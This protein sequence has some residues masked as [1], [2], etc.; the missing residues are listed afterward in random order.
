[1]F[2]AIARRFRRGLMVSCLS[3]TALVSPS[4]RA[5][6]LDGDVSLTRELT[7]GGLCTVSFSLSGSLGNAYVFFDNEFTL[8]GGAYFSELATVPAAAV[9]TLGLADC[10]ITDVTDFVQI[11]AGTDFASQAYMGFTFSGREGGVLY[12][13]EYALVGATNTQIVSTRTVPPNDPPTVAE[14]AD[15]IVASG[16]EYVM[17]V[18]ATDDDELGYGWQQVDTGGLAPEQVPGFSSP[19]MN[20]RAPVLAGGSENRRLVFEVRVEDG[21]NP[22]V[23]RDVAVTVNAPPVITDSSDVSPVA[24]AETFSVTVTDSSDALTYSWTQIDSSGLV[25]TDAIGETTS[26]FRV[27]PPVLPEGS[28]PTTLTYRVSVSDGV[29]TAI[30]Q[31]F[32]FTVTPPVNTPPTVDAGPDRTVGSGLTIGLEGSASDPDADA[33]VS[34]LWSAP[35]GGGTFS[36][37]ADAGSFYTA[38]KVAAGSPA[39]EITLTLEAADGLDTATSTMIV[40]VTPNAAPVVSAGADQTVVSGGQVS[41]NASATDADEADVAAMQYT[42]EAPEGLSFSFGSQSP[43]FTAPTLAVNAP[44]AVFDL[45]VTGTDGTDSDSDAMRLTVTSRKNVAPVAAAQS[46]GTVAAGQTITLSAAGTTDADEGDLDTLQ[47]E[48]TQTSGPATVLQGSLTSTATFA[49][50]TPVPTS[51]NG[52]YGFRVTVTDDDGATSTADVE[53]ELLS[54]LTPLEVTAMASQA[55]A[56]TGDFVQLSANVLGTNPAGQV[57]YNWTTDADIVIINDETQ[58]TTGFVAPVVTAPVEATFV[59]TVTET[60]PLRA[61]RMVSATVRVTLS[62]NSAPQVLVTG[63]ATATEGDSVTLDASGSSDAETSRLAIFWTQT[64]GPDVLP[65]ET[66]DDEGLKVRVV[67][68]GYRG[69]SITFT[70]PAVPEGQTELALVFDVMV[71]DGNTALTTTRTVT[72]TRAPTDV[73]E[74]TTE[75]EI[76]QTQAQVEEFV[77]TRMSS[78]IGLQPDLGGVFSGGDGTAD[79]TVSSM[80]GQVDLS[81]APDQPFWLRLKGNWSTINGAEG[82]Y[83][84]GAAGTHVLLGEGLA[85]GV[86]G[87]VDHMRTVDGLAVAEGTGYL[88]GPYVVAKMPDHPLVVQGRLLFGASQN[89]FSPLGT[90]E[91]SFDAKRLLAQV[92]ASGQIAKGDVIW[93]PS[94]QAAYALE[95]TEAYVDGVGNPIG[96]TENAVAQVAAGIDVTFPLPVPSGAMTATLGLADIWAGSVSGGPAAYE[97]HRGRVSFGVNRAFGSGAELS[98]TGSYDGLGADGFESVGLDLLFKHEF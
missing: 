11:G 54:P 89:T 53:I 90:Y 3:V 59:V 65:V 21:V 61:P 27:T 28:G 43:I 40:T 74:D 51:E 18:T 32:S 41:L 46:S 71:S 62:P 37:A 23:V 45:T 38:P 44:D 10:G 78:L 96:S 81:T 70:A 33:V 35:A 75:A 36:D 47:Y 34:Y 52:S 86:M 69:P 55:T 39:R 72:V 13:Y 29:N 15:L 84:L 22:A 88:V 17:E 24:F 2:N 20:M 8:A 98:L 56:L 79:L 95:E 1:M 94:L 76:A 49:L 91:D 19:L 80:G 83:V 60:D 7:E 12:D 82:D 93:K 92:G 68:R 25:G 87:Q 57:F 50:P 77:Q 63:P 73:P 64:A 31:D 97:G 58:P 16:A 6:A 42:W 67:S 66:D 26:V 5:D 30:T 9:T 85:L 48:W 14:P 4:G